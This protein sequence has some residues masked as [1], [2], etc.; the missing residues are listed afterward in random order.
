MPAA[1]AAPTAAD[2]Y[3]PAQNQKFVNMLQEQPDVRPEALE[4]AKSLAA[5][6]DYP[7]ANAIAQLAKL[8]IADAGEQ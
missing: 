6:P 2:S 7:G 8:I 3:Q 4:R 1:A 5:D